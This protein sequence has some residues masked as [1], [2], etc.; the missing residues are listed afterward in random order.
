MTTTATAPG[1]VSVPV[2]D[3]DQVHDLPAAQALANLAHIHQL[4]RLEHV[5]RVNR[6]DGHT[7]VMIALPDAHV[8]DAWRAALGAPPYVEKRHPLSSQWTTERTC[9]FGATVRLIYATA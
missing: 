3:L 8:A 6:H 5:Y 7:V 9:W 2:D 1:V 4:P